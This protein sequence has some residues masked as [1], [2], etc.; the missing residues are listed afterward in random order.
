M[1]AMCTASSMYTAV[2]CLVGLH[3]ISVV[4]PSIQIFFFQDDN[5]SKFQWIFAKL[6]MSIDI[7]EICFGI[8]NGQILSVF[9]GSL[10]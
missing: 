6:G 7:V 3:S 9:D 2:G 5:L 1:C 4:P 8:A 10:P